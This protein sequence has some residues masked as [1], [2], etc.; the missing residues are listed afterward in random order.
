[1]W[2]SVRISRL[3]NAELAMSAQELTA[4][5]VRNIIIVVAI[6]YLLWH[7]IATTTWPETL[8]AQTWL[9]TLLMAC[10]CGIP[11]LLLQSRPCMALVIWHVGLTLTITVAVLVYHQPLLMCAYMLLPFMATVTMGAW[12]GILAEG[13][14]LASIYAIL[15]L[16]PM[17]PFTMTHGLGIAIGAGLAGLVGW[18]ASQA[19]YTVTQWALISLEQMR[20][21]MEE[22]RRRRAQLAK[23]VKDLDQAYYRLERTNSSLVAAWKAA[24]EAERFKAEF[25]TNVSH[26]LRTPLNLI[27]GFAEMMMTSPESYGNIPIPG[28]YRSDLTCIY[29]SAQHVLNLVDDVLDLARIQ[30]GKIPLAIEQVELTSLVTEAVDMVRD[31]IAAKGLDLRVTMEPNLPVL[32][33][34]RLRIRQVLLNL[35]I[36]AARFT[37]HGSISVNVARQAD[38]VTVRVTDTGQGIPS[39][40]LPRIFE[41][42]RTTKVQGATWHTGTGLGLPISKKLVELHHGQ[43]GV[44]SRRG[45]R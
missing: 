20:E 19:L 6:A 30:A 29:Q 37:E 16:Q 2:E 8:S 39:E 1:M 24:D 17:P 31:Y 34:D 3:N 14:G 33:V 7:I 15:R 18:A 36:N 44:E 9:V 42:F 25:V 40:E 22:A 21:N 13:A 26:E 12:P 35:L 23:V 27:I 5:M 43:M 11:L 45:A 10:T 41:E 4:I 28:P 38:E 32:A